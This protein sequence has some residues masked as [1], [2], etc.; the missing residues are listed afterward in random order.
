MTEEIKKFDNDEDDLILAVARESIFS[1]PRRTTPCRKYIRVAL[2]PKRK[3]EERKNSISIVPSLNLDEE[4]SGGD[5]LV[6]C[7][8]TLLMYIHASE[9][10]T[11]NLKHSR[12]KN[13]GGVIIM[14]K[15]KKKKKK[16]AWAQCHVYIFSLSLPLTYITSSFFSV[17]FFSSSM[18]II[19]IWKRCQRLVQSYTFPI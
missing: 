10:T 16:K 8:V 15:K 19:Y 4:I 11:W 18:A 12:K 3:T 7:N 6:A 14:I 1:Q 13:Q 9:R 2:I 5:H 17:S